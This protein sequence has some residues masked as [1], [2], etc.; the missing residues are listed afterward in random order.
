MGLGRLVLKLL[1][2]SPKINGR[3]AA[4]AASPYAYYRFKNYMDDPSIDHSYLGT[5]KETLPLILAAFLAGYL[6]TVYLYAKTRIEEPNQRPQKGDR[7]KV[8]NLE[9]QMLEHTPPSLFLPGKKTLDYGFT[10]MLFLKY[11]TG[12]KLEKKAREQKNPALALDALILYFGSE[13]KIDDGFLLLRDAFDWLEG[14][15]P[16]LNFRAKLAYAYT[17]LAFEISRRLGPRDIKVYMM[18]AAHNSILKPEKTWHWSALGRMVADEFKLEHRTEMYVF[19]ALIA[20]AQKRSDT[21]EAWKDAFTVLKE[22]PVWERLGETR[23]IVRVL[24]NNKF[25]SNTLIFKARESREALVKEA[26][27]GATLASLIED[28][29][30]PQPLYIVQEP[31]E[32][33]YVSIMRRLKGDTLYERLKANDKEPIS[34]VISALAKIH[35]HFPTEKYQKLDI[36]KNL[37][38]KLKAHE[39]GLPSELADRI[40]E[41]YAPVHEAITDGA[42]W[43][44]NKDAHPENWIIGDKIGVID[45]EGDYLIPALFDLVNL[46]E[47]GDFFSEKEKQSNINQYIV[48]MHSESREIN[49]GTASRAYRNSVIHRAIALTSAWSSPDR[50]RMHIYRKQTIRKALYAIDETMK[51]DKYYYERHKDKYLHL[52]KAFQELHN[53]IPS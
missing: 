21:G 27:A 4:L 44:W 49:I 34:R 15:T 51:E 30:V 20:T 39:L 5:V 2:K 28:V 18:K 48:N 52:H 3:I 26:E 35:A 50:T 38:E 46:Q 42:L 17:N 40:I 43:V 11:K 47:Y 37:E 10:D 16:E 13:R 6:G 12:T 24:K 53:L 45:N 31:Y 41:N 23:S 14:S 36:K 7:K 25:F 22:Q 1:T 19:H 33:K 8:K 9:E 29:D 32:G